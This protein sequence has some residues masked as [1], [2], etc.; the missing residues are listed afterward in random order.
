MLEKLT[1]LQGVNY[2]WKHQVDEE[3]KYSFIAQ[4]V[5]QIFFPE[6]VSTGS[7]GYK[8]VAYGAFAP[9]LV[10]ATKELV[11]RCQSEEAKIESLEE[12]N[13]RLKEDHLVFRKSLCELG[14]LRFCN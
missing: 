7:N 10:E 1:Q 6:F 12:E 13:S 14:V 4:D 3:A 2:K 9:I 11:H 5:E 8:A